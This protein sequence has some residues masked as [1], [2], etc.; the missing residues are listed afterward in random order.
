MDSTATA[1]RKAGK[2]ARGSFLISEAF[3]PKVDNVKLAARAGIK[4]IMQTGGSI[5]DEEVIKAADRAKICMI[6]TGVRHF[7]H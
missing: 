1:I 3:L 5:Y 6:L 2:N 7:K 4:V